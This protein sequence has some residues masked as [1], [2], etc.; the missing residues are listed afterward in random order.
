M[1]GTASPRNRLTRKRRRRGTLALS[2]LIAV[3]GLT[4]TASAAFGGFDKLAKTVRDHVYCNVVRDC[5]YNDP[6]NTRIV[7]GPEGVT[8]NPKP[9]FRFESNEEGVKY[10]CRVDDRHF[11]TCQNPYTT[12]HLRDGRHTLEVFAVDADG[13]KDETP[14]TREFTVDTDDPNCHVVKG[15]HKTHDRTPA[16][17]LNS[18]EKH[19]RFEYRV[20]RKGKFHRTGSKVKLHKLRPGKHLLEARAVDK[21]GNAD[22]S[23]DKYQF[24]IVGGKHGHGNGH[25][26]GHGHN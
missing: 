14:A 9:T 18:N 1:D 16:F 2:S 4:L 26:H 24:K 11:H 13:N 12:Y 15:P 23:P 25:G 17:I 8:D 6:P 22:R 10:K 20:D 3:L 7:K 5:V 21:A 19:P